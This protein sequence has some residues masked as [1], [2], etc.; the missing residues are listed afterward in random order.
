MQ[1]LKSDER[2]PRS[3]LIGRVPQGSFGGSKILL[4]AEVFPEAGS[5]QSMLDQVANG[6]DGPERLRLNRF[7]CVNASPEGVQ[8]L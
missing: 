5:S 2:Q 3:L 8:D 4:V 6:C 7:V 1:L